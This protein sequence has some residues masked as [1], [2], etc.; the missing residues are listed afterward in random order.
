M[1]SYCTNQSACVLS[2]SRVYLYVI[3]ETLVKGFINHCHRNDCKTD[4]YHT[5]TFLCII[6]PSWMHSHI[7]YIPSI[8]YV[9][10]L[11]YLL[12]L[13]GAAWRSG[14]PVWLVMWR[15]WVQAP[16]KAPRCF[17]DQDPCCLVLVGFRNGFER[18]FPIELK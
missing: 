15:S 12:T 5:Y 17:L 1:Y 4:L 2:I 18:D 8:L 16:S 11:S 6:F 10:V 14:L 3:F 7:G 13:Y 9:H